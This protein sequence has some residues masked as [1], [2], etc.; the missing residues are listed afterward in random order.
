MRTVFGRHI[1]LPLVIDLVGENDEK[2]N[3]RYLVAFAVVEAILVVFGVRLLVK[4][5]TGQGAFF[6]VVAI[7]LV[8]VM[9][10]TAFAVIHRFLRPRQ[11]S[12]LTTAEREALKADPNGA[13]AQQAHRVER[14]GSV[15][16]RPAAEQP[17][18]ERT[19]GEDPES[20]STIEANR[21]AE[22]RQTIEWLDAIVAPREV[23]LTTADGVALTAHV[24]ECALDSSR[25]AV[26]VH[27]YA[28]DWTD[29]MLY[30]RHYANLGFNL[31]M[32]VMRAHGTS[33]GKPGLGWLDRTDLVAWC[34]WI[35]QNEDEGARIVLHG[36]GLGASAAC[37]A[38]GEKTLPSG[39]VA[40]VCDSA[41]SDAWN[42]LARILR[43]KGTPVHPLIDA[44]RLVF[45]ALPG[46]FDLTL[47]S[48][49]DAVVHAQVPLLLF[50]GES[51]PVVPPYMSKKIYDAASGAA[52]GE[53]KRLR[54]FKGAGHFESS[55]IDPNTYY[56]ELF[57][58]LKTR[59]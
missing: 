7:A 43:A 42:S 44:I 49:S 58:F 1:S 39:V 29:M 21:V 57:D 37:I 10:V 19:H 31:L 3:L 11:I 28:G 8:V 35:T 26:L 51:D 2:P 9:A 23:S 40:C 24:F 50:Q 14:I 16:G 4:G 6:I 47:A 12:Q 27:G 41:F 18:A 38:A 34:R 13:L 48:A 52:V 55:L 59:V 32:P 30:A 53:N 45:M 22:A 25:W 15:L 33:G 54:M 46:G 5:S 36:H 17:F 20:L 56:H